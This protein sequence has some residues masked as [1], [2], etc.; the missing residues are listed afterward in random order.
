MLTKQQF[1]DRMN[2]IKKYEERVETFDH[3]LKEFAPS[4]FTGFYDETIYE[5]L[6]KSIT[7]DM[8]DEYDTISWWMCETEWG[9]KKDM[10]KI[11]RGEKG[12]ADYQE[13]SLLT[14]SDLYDY[15]EECQ[16]ERVN[17]ELDET[18]SDHEDTIYDIGCKAQTEGVRFALNEISTISLT[19]ENTQNPGWESRAAFLKL[20][21]NQI[22]NHYLQET[23]LNADLQ[24][25]LELFTED[26]DE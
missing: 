5:Y 4:D 10:C 1:I 2:F 8:N 14:L 17:D 24:E 7:E 19:N 6:L 3:A 20:V 22:R 21:Y 12:D 15:L 13:W 26:I 16:W 11:T 18:L 9:K 25:P 23:G